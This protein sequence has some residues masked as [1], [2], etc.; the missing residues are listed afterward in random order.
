MIDTHSH[1]DAEEFQDDVEQVILRAKEAGV[2]KILIPNI[3][4]DTVEPVLD[5]CRRHPGILFPMM[6]LHP[7]DVNPHKIDVARTLDHMETLL[8][9]EDNPYVAVGEVGLDF[10]WDDT[11]RTKQ[12]AV[13]ERQVEWALQYHLPLMIHAREA[14]DDIV[15][16]IE[17]YHDGSLV[18]LVMNGKH[19]N[20]WNSLG[21]ASVL[22]ECSPSRSPRCP[23]C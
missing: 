9:K 13:F 1:I 19:A 6:G 20:C 2:E 23:S 17:K 8:K 4:A 21:S 15:K 14:H 7:E 11:F 16:V 3:N 22:V 5:L 10:Y 18:S 12:I